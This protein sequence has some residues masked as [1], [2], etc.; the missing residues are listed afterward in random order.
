[1]LVSLLISGCFENYGRLKHNDDIT[2][3]FQTDQVEPNYKYY[4]YGRTNMPYAIVGIDRAYHMRSRVWRE[5]DHDTEQFSKM[6]FWVWDDPRYAYQRNFTRGA[7]I[8]DPAGKR[9]GI[10]YSGLRWA[11]VRFEDDRRIVV[12]PEPPLY[13]G[14]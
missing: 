1:M 2:R 9:V 7:Y 13:G 5:V 3:T 12:M 10:W 14:P 11:A 4:Y 6:V 8:L